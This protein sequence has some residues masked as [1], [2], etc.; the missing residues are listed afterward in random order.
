M[1]EG[2]RAH[3]LPL[4]QQRGPVLIRP[5]VTDPLIDNKVTS[6]WLCYGV[7]IYGG[8][9]NF[10]VNR[11]NRTIYHWH[12]WYIIMIVWT[13]HVPYPHKEMLRKKIKYLISPYL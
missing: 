6:V 8:I 12:S 10:K 1:G 4:G 3:T 7:A 9:T 11:H 2:E 5:V 13:M